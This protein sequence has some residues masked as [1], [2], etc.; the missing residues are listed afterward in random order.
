MCTSVRKLQK[1]AGVR[2]AIVFEVELDE[3]KLRRVLFGLFVS[4]KESPLPVAFDRVIAIGDAGGLQSPLSPIGYG[5][6][7]TFAALLDM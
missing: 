7:T 2:R 4:Y 6:E 5:C 3:L 1:F